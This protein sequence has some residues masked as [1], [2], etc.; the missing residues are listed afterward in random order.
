MK[1]YILIPTIGLVALIMLAGCTKTISALNPI[2][3]TN[4]GANQTNYITFTSLPAGL[5]V[6]SSELPSQSNGQVT[7]TY[8]NNACSGYYMNQ[9]GIDT[10][11]TSGQVNAGYIDITNAVAG[12]SCP[13]VGSVTTYTVNVVFNG[14]TYNV[15]GTYTQP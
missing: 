1:K 8:S 3:T 10:V 7:V 2:G 12:I 5:T 4:A 14:T 15:S 6:S 9:N 13:S 11:T